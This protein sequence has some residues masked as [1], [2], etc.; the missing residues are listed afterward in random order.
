MEK[1]NELIKLDAQL[2]EQ[3]NDDGLM[4]I[5]GG[6]VAT[7]SP[8]EEEVDIQFNIYQCNPKCK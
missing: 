1:N 2:L 3:F 6:N 5:R 4:V 7:G 8:A